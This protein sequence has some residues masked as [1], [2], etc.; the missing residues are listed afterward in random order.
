V[1]DQD[2]Y[3]RSPQNHLIVGF[4]ILGLGVILL[5]DRIGI[6]AADRIFLFW[7]LLVIWWG[8]RMFVHANSLSRRFWGGFVLLVGISFQVQALGIGHVRF[9]TVWPV[10]LI[11][12]GIVLILKRYESRNELRQGPP[13][14]PPQPGPTIDVPPAPPGPPPM[15]PMDI[16][17]SG[18]PP[19]PGPPPYQ[20]EPT[21]GSTATPP[22]P[23]TGAANSSSH[24]SGPPPAQSNFASAPTGQRWPDRDKPW[25]DFEKNVHDFGQ[26]MD[27]FGERMYENWRGNAS[28]SANYSQSGASQ[29]NEVNIFWGGRKKII[30]KQFVG[31]EVVAIFGGYEIDLTEAEMAGDYIEIEA[32]NIFG[33]GEIR[34]PLG[35]DVYM[36]A[37]GIFGGCGDR[38]RHPDPVPAGAKNPDGSPAPQPKRLI[39]KGV[40]IFGG[41]TVRN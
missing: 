21:P 27:Q 22:P 5:L 41:L 37:V 10:L 30:A 16:P 34:V 31:G 35:W 40:A 6:L 17:P 29:L 26:K 20:A 3:R 38:T 32:V 24:F 33:G 2:P 8:Y 14:V 11:C 36:Q 4:V 13:N 28:R 12:A 15:T 25:N 7:P 19:P 18:S 23:G 39:V 9:D 1:P